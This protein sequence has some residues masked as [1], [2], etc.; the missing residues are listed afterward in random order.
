MCLDDVYVVCLFV[1]NLW[2][3]LYRGI[4]YVNIIIFEKIF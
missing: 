1:I 4:I 2:G 3:K